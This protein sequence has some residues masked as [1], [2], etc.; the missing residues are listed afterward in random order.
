MI[1]DPI[2]GV[3]PTG[4]RLTFVRGGGQE[5]KHHRRKKVFD[6]DRLVCTRDM[7]N[8]TTMAAVETIETP[9]VATPVKVAKKVR[10]RKPVTPKAPRAPREP[11][12]FEKLGVVEQIIL[13]F[14]PRS[15]WAT[16]FGF[17]LGGFV[18]LATFVLAHLEVVSDKALYEQPIM[19]LV[20]GGLAFSLKTVI[21]WG[22]MAFHFPIKAFGFAILAE[23]TM[24]M[25]HTPWL[26]YMA[27]SYLIGINGI[28]TG[29]RL[30]LHKRQMRSDFGL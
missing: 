18:P 27:L 10:V 17:L 13:A 30:V 6:S 29:C 25:S 15:R 9:V 14:R 3:T 2:G 12:T 22:K 16:A 21:D 8:T 7:T 28:A 24:V 20:L 5:K 4:V 11:V 19:L 23:G 26:T 1:P